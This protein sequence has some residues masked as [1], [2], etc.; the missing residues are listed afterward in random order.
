MKI[1]I[2]H[3]AKTSVILL[4]LLALF[5]GL[6]GCGGNQAAGDAAEQEALEAQIVAK[7]TPKTT[8]TTKQVT[9]SK[10]TSR[11]T[12]TTKKVIPKLTDVSF[13]L[14]LAKDQDFAEYTTPIYI[15]ANQ[16]LHLNWIVIKGGE[17]FYLTFTLPNGKFIAVRGDGTLASYIP[18]EMKS[19]QLRANGSVVFYPNDNNWGDGYYIFH[20][21]IYRDDPSI[22]VKLMYYV[23]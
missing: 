19:E 21:Q 7:S 4:S 12:T 2:N 3:I 6:I 13:T 9:T 18:G 11:T 14:T 5:M 8:T 16:T 15:M 17:Y 10:T 23:E 22:T 1:V 20:P